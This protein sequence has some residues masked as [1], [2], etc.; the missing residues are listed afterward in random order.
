MLALSVMPEVTRATGSY[1]VA[2]TIM[3]LFGATG[4][5]LSPVRAALVDRH[6]PGPALLILS[7]PRPRSRRPD[8]R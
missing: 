3:V 6:G 7:G 1:A 4:V 2:G 5:F 8:G